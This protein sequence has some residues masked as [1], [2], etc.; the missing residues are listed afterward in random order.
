MKK[1]EAQATYFVARG[2][3]VAIADATRE[4]G[5][6]ITLRPGALVTLPAEEAARLLEAGFLSE[7]PPDLTP[8]AA[9]SNLANVGMQDQMLQYQGPRYPDPPP[10]SMRGATS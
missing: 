7:T 2:R 10:R 1:P 5:A 6:T 9:A 4:P 8:V 3:S